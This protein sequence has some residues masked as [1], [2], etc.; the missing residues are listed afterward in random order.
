MKNDVELTLTILEC[1]FKFGP[2]ITIEDLCLRAK[3]SNKKVKCVL[4]VLVKRGYI[5]E[6]KDSNEYMLSRKIA[7]LA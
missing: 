7:L 4:A 2:S 3:V 1:C 6:G 5:T